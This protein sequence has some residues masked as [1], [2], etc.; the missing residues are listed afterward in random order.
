MKVFV[1]IVERDG[2]TIKEPG[3]TE[4]EIRREEYLFAASDIAQVWDTIDTIRNDPEA[5]LIGVYE[6]Y[7]AIQVLALQSHAT[8]RQK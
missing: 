7:P 4:T 1:V 3:I 8:E 5:H 6:K 2:R